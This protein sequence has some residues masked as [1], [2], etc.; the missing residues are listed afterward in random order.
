MLRW[1]WSFA[2]TLAPEE[3]FTTVE[4]EKQFLPPAVASTT[5]SGRKGHTAGPNDWLRGV[6]HN[7]RGEPIGCESGLHLHRSSRP[8]GQAR[9]EDR[10]ALSPQPSLFLLSYNPAELWLSR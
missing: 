6:H 3:S 9:P 2:S 7:P 5:Q 1:A 10:D 4:P 8:R